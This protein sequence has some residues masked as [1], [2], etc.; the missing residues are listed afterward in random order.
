MQRRSN[1]NVSMSGA[2]RAED[3]NFLDTTSGF[4]VEDLKI[5]QDVKWGLV[6]SSS[7]FC[8]PAI[9]TICHTPWLWWLCLSYSTT[10]F[11]SVNYWRNPVPGMRG[12]LDMYTT[13]HL[14]FLITVTTGALYVRDRFWLLVGWPLAVMIPVFFWASNHLSKRGDYL[15]SIAHMSMHACISVGMSIV[16]AGATKPKTDPW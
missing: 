2:I 15:W 13:A 16:V 6:L 11:M 12:N 4:S 8:L 14:S 9:L 10:S 1:N 5:M 3:T 7:T